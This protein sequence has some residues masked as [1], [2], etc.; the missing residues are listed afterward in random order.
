MIGC[1]CRIINSFPTFTVAIR[2]ES[3]SM[4][5]IPKTFLPNQILLGRSFLRYVT[6]SLSSSAVSLLSVSGIRYFH[7]HSH[8]RIS[9]SW[10]T[11][12]G[13]ISIGGEAYIQYVNSLF[14]L[15]LSF[16]ASKSCHRSSFLCSHI[17]WVRYIACTIS[18]Y[19]LIH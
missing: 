10:V 19:Q 1:L 14:F 18:L 4:L 13:A 11:F 15:L 12:S 6:C 2:L 3:I 5:N 8:L 9:A 17:Y 7:F 16:L